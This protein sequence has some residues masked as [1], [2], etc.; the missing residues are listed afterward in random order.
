MTSLVR[1]AA[2]SLLMVFVAP[3]FTCAQQEFPPPQGS[4]RLVLVISGAMGAN[5]YTGMAQV[6]AS[7]GYDAVLVDGNAMEGTQGAALRTAIEQARKMPHAQPGKFAIVGFSLGGG[8]ALVYGTTRPDAIAGVVLWY[9]ATSYMKDF[10]GWANRLAVPVLMFAGES[11]AYKNC[12]LIDTA[13]KLQVAASVAKK[14]FELVTYPA[15]QH[16]FIP[17]Q[18]TY[19]PQ[20]YNDAL[21]RMTARLKQYF[22]P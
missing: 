21:Q 19:N 15:T 2:L 22:S 16:D 7:L 4:G 1:I 5:A 18:R 12:C 14:P 8:I 17:G 9:P 6:I 10:D 11:D 13:R 3:V 20:A